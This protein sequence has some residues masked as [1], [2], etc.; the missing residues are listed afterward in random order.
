MVHSLRLD[1]RRRHLYCFCTVELTIPPTHAVDQLPGGEVPRSLEASRAAEAKQRAA[2]EAEWRA[3]TGR[4]RAESIN[5]RHADFAVGQGAAQGFTFS[6]KTRYF[7]PSCHQ[8]LMLAYGEW[9]EDQ[10]L[11]STRQAFRACNAEC[12]WNADVMM[13]RGM[14]H[15]T[16]DTSDFEKAIVFLDS[17]QKTPLARRTVRDYVSNLRLPRADEIWRT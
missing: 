11:R 17:R 12:I 15:N 8:R 10:A 5:H 2:T 16:P 13:I 14:G 9:L 4:R 7:C 6:C 3:R 1:I